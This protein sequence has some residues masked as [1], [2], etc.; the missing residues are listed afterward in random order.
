MVQGQQYY[1]QHLIGDLYS[2]SRARIPKDNRVNFVTDKEQLYKI[3]ELR[4]RISLIISPLDVN[5]LPIT[6]D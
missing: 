2:S 6:I 3:T 1:I 4:Q 5:R